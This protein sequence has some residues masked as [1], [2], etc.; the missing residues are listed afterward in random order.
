MGKPQDD[1]NRQRC[2]VPFVGPIPLIDP[3]GGV[4]HSRPVDTFGSRLRAARELA[5]PPPKKKTLSTNGLDRLAGI[6]VGMTSRYENEK[7]SRPDRETVMKLAR[8]LKVREA[9]L[10]DGEG[11]MR[12]P[13][14][15]APTFRNHPRW[16]ELCAQ[17]KVMRALTD[18]DLERIADS[19]FIWAPME[20]LDA[21]L[22]ADL[23]SNLRDWA[24]RRSAPKI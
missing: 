15:S 10:F 24:A 18:E 3:E 16:A 19:P 21:A 9:W 20:S 23:A 12:E 13:P 1:G 17:A 11:P 4:R 7:R 22:V 14:P 5:P 2:Q 6:S 8:A